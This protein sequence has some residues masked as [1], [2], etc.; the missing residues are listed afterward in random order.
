MVY[1]LTFRTFACR[2]EEKDWGI[3]MP[4]NEI[5]SKFKSM[6]QLCAEI[7]NEFV[8]MDKIEKEWNKNIQ[9][10]KYQCRVLENRIEALNTKIKGDPP[11]VLPFAG[12]IGFVK[13]GQGKCPECEHELEKRQA[14]CQYAS[15]YARLDEFLFC[16][17]C[18]THFII[19]FKNM[20]KCRTRYCKNPAYHNGLC[21]ECLKHNNYEVR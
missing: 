17:K 19:E 20:P 18:K 13:P 12:K 3:A 16:S 5:R 10:L 14:F 11:K 1:G 8:E 9:G 21:F 7:E 2:I 15:H 4:A 6:R